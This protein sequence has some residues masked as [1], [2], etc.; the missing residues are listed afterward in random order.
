MSTEPPLISVII[1]TFNCYSTLRSAIESALSQTYKNIEVIVIDDGSSD[2][3]PSIISS[4]INSIIYIKQENRGVAEA[5]NVGVRSSNGEWIAFLDA[6]DIWDENKLERQFSKMNDEGNSWSYTDTRFVGGVNSGRLDSEFTK[7]HTGSVF[8]ELLTNNFIS[9]S[10]VLL[11]KSKFH[12]AGG[13][14][15]TLPAI[16][17]WELWVRISSKN[18]VSYVDQPLTTYRVHKKSTSRNTRKVLPYHLKAISVIFSKNQLN[19]KQ[20]KFIKK[21]KSNSYTICSYISEEEN[22]HAFSLY[23]A[24]KS[25]INCPRSLKCILRIIRTSSNLIT[26]SK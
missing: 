26:K 18:A 15:T 14:D 22:D 9:T 10:T 6:D 24:I 11:K 7:K 1:P 13:F 17:D 20:R 19:K 25:F 12:N 5:R 3:T 4:Y 21:A 16:E 23:C 8:N 2:E